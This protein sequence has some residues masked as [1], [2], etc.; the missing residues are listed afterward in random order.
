MKTITPK[1]RTISKINSH[2]F[3]P[4][5]KS[6][7]SVLLTVSLSLLS[8]SSPP[9]LQAPGTNTEQSGTQAPQPVW[10]KSS[11]QALQNWSESD[12]DTLLKAFSA[13]CSTGG[14]LLA[15][16]KSTPQGLLD[17]CRKVRHYL[18]DSKRT[19][20]SAWM[21]TQFDVWQF[22]QADGQRKGLLTGYYEPELKGSRT[23]KPPY[24]VPL[25]GV[26]N[27][28]ISVELAG[29]YPELK[30]KRLR[31]RLQGSTLVPFFDRKEWEKIGPS[32]EIPL[33]W[34]DDK[35]DAFLLQVQ[36]SGR[37]QLN[38]GQVI[39]L[40]YADQNGHP[41]RAIGKV[42]VDRGTLRPEQATIP[43]IR[44]W[45]KKNP[46]E[47]DA[48]LDENPSVVFFQENK[49]LDPSQGPI[50]ALGVSLTP[51]LS[52]AVDQ[53]LVPYGSLLWIASTHPETKTTIAQ[54]ML[55]QD[56][57]GAIRGRVRADYFWGTGKTAGEL[58]GITR[59]PLELWLIWPKAT[60]LPSPEP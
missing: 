32:R 31:G 26:P 4:L 37:V 10:V 48:L 5:Q 17:A 29:L 1:A 34:V 25:Y 9:P 43:G 14:N 47:L 13:Q 3:N 21:Q 42:L 60:P 28:L 24:V 44:L 53:T 7:L 35:L 50:G 33:A 46:A 11:F 45:A 49:V 57:G 19:P 39:R 41:Y 27:D 56:T 6:G 15:K 22:Q 2:M 16:R 23:R 36:G 20:S 30:G 55:A 18:S 54:G 8:C 12:L 52:L 38:D 58:A 40:G 51:H 59:Q